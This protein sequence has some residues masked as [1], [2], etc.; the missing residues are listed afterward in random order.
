[1]FSSDDCRTKAIECYRAA[2]KA[3][4][5]DAGRKLLDLSVE[6][7]ELG[8]LMDRMNKENGL[9]HWRKSV[10]LFYRALRLSARTFGR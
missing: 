1:M 3:T 4:N 5:Y 9:F 2:Q 10:D 8:D 7:R 6:W